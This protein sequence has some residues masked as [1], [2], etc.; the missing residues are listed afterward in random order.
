MTEAKIFAAP[1]QSLTL[2]WLTWNAN[3]YPLVDRSYEIQLM[4]IVTVDLIL[5]RSSVNR[6]R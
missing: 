3:Q 4:L 1:F 2:I 6:V 5:T